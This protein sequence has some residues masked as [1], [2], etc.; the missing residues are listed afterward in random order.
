MQQLMLG[1]TEFTSVKVGLTARASLSIGKQG[2][3][4]LAH[5][6][7]ARAAL[8]YNITATI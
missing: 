1:T 5:P 8:T 2:N 7:L 6:Q 3:V 4:A